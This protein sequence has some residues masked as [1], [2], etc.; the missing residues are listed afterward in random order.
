M[1]SQ[2]STETELA[3]VETPEQIEPYLKHKKNKLLTFNEEKHKTKLSKDLL[4][5]SVGNIKTAETEFENTYYK[6]IKKNK[7]TYYKGAYILLDKSKGNLNEVNELRKKII[8][9]FNKGIDFSFLAQ[10]HSTDKNASRGGDLGWF[11]L[12]E[13]HTRIAE[14]IVN[15]THS[16]NKI[17]TVEVPNENKYY[18]VVMTDQTKKIK[19][20][21]VLKVVK[22]K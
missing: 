4:A 12:D 16:I 6:V 20:V 13:V 22:Q 1:T 3:S 15:E 5:L 8:A 18:L 21:D 11:T 2:S 14:E 19:E 10:Q 17:F 7:R 9:E